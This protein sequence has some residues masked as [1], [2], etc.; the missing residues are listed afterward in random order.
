[1]YY[2]GFGF[3]RLILP[4]EFHKNELLIIPFIGLAILV[5]ISYNLAYIGLNSKT[6]LLIFFVISTILN[7]IAIKRRKQI[8]LNTHEN[9]IPILISFIVLLVALIPLI[10]IGYLTIIGANGDAMT[11]TLVSEYLEDNGLKVSVISSVDLGIINHRLTS[12][13]P[14]GFHFFQSFI[15]I[16]SGTKA[17]MN[18]SL[19]TA[20]FL[21]LNI[22]STYVFARYMGLDTKTAS[23]AICF[24]AFNSVLIWGHYDGFGPQILGI[25]LMPLALGSG[26]NA[27]KN[28]SKRSF[29]F[30]SLLLA[31][32]FS[33]YHEAAYLVVIP[34]GIYAMWS[35]F[36]QNENK[37]RYI[38]ALS[39]MIILSI[40]INMIKGIPL[41]TEFLYRIFGELN[42]FVNKIYSDSIGS[43]N[44]TTAVDYGPIWNIW[45]NIPIERIYGL[46][47]F[48]TGYIS[49]YGFLA[50]PIIQFVVLIMLFFIICI[51][52]YGLYHAKNRKE[53]FAIIAPFIFIYYAL[54]YTYNPYYYFKVLTL[55]MFI[56]FIVLAEGVKK[57]YKLSR[58]SNIRI[59]ARF[60]CIIF[61]ALFMMFNLYSIYILTDSVKQNGI[62]INKEYI[63]AIGE[64]SSIADKNSKILV[65]SQGYE[66]YDQWA[67][68]FL[69][70]Y[71]FFG[72]SVYYKNIGQVMRSSSASSYNIDNF[73][74]DVDFILYRSANLSGI[75]SNNF[76]KIWHNTNL[77]IYARNSSVL[78]HFPAE[79][80]KP[81]STIYYHNFK[82]LETGDTVFYLS[83]NNSIN[84]NISTGLFRVN[85]NRYIITNNITNVSS[86]G[87][88]FY[89]FENTTVNISYDDTMY[90][91]DFER[92]ATLYVV[93]ITKVPADIRIETNSNISNVSVDWFELYDDTRLTR[94]EDK[95]ILISATTNHMSSNRTIDEFDNSTTLKIISTRNGNYLNVNISVKYPYNATNA[96]LALDIYRIEEAKHPEY[97][98]GFWSIDINRGI[99]NISISLDM[100]NK[101]ALIFKD[102]KIVKHG[103]W[104]GNISSGEFIARAV[105]WN[106]N[107]PEYA[108]EV[109]R[110]KISD[111]KVT[112]FTGK[113]EMRSYTANMRMRIYSPEKDLG[114]WLEMNAVEGYLAP[115]YG[116]FG[117][118]SKGTL[119]NYN[120]YGYYGVRLK[121]S[122]D[123]QY[124]TVDLDLINKSAII[125][126][127]SNSYVYPF[128]HGGVATTGRY[129]A[130]LIILDDS[131]NKL[132]DSFEA[133][134]INID[135]NN[136]IS[137]FKYN[138][139][140]SMLVIRTWK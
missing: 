62:V 21:A 131:E 39:I 29:I 111:S 54:I 110:F 109:S 112:K 66:P 15:D 81:A 22:F 75:Y 122:S 69:K 16:I 138:N 96:T 31:A 84:V 7:F 128:I 87:I 94:Y 77:S 33:V 61:V 40:F 41:A 90:T 124:V 1:M 107:L 42:R 68:Y 135:I 71:N 92:G 117:T 127:T 23:L 91:V 102:N 78:G 105:L 10:N 72:D 70:G 14:I 26:F 106:N 2:I 97:H 43:V 89:V 37:Y 123:T 28:P 108:E 85:Q 86:L 74:D 82:F 12:N 114:I 65:M 5:T 55:T 57:L 116:Y 139:Y 46:M 44:P 125:T 137:L 32:V 8:E 63:E 79:T 24:I 132:I 51:S 113:N 35:F 103:S 48:K 27:I 38:G 4:Y 134:Y 59:Q 34:I 98:Y 53:L 47:P 60:L 19:L 9:I 80:L 67:P 11:H 115:S 64:L 3:S 17:Y 49:D 136:S 93:N 83:K 20:L 18:F 118:Y 52:L 6:S 130:N 73:I 133:A 101:T 140:D 45:Y 119:Q 126:P 36:V 76:D 56:L 104:V 13:Y 50:L 100:I 30:G 99:Q 120:S 58:T 121:K 129:L 95:K 25:S 88:Q